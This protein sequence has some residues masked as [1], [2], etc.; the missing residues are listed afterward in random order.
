VGGVTPAKKANAVADAFPRITSEDRETLVRIVESAIRAVFHELSDAE[1]VVKPLYMKRGQSEEE[2]IRCEAY[3]E[4]LMDVRNQ[5][6]KYSIDAGTTP[7]SVM[8]SARK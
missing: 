6:H 2:K 5:I 7:G 8:N 1:R 4:W 3:K